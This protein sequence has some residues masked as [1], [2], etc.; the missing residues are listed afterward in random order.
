MYTELYDSQVSC[1]RLDQM[2][3]D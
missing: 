3:T 1:T 2:S